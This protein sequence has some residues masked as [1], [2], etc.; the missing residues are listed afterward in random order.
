LT[1]SGI[2]LSKERKARFDV[3]DVV[4][5]HLSQGD[6]EVSRAQAS[7]EFTSPTTT[8]TSGLSPNNTSSNF[9]ISEV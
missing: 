2:E 9:I 1:S 3:G 4:W 8:T 5:N 7:V 6:L